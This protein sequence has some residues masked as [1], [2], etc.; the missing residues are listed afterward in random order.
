MMKLKPKLF[1][2]LLATC[3]ISLQA[4]GQNAVQKAKI[5]GKTNV[6]ELRQMQ[7]KLGKDYQ[8]NY[9]KALRI[10]KAKGWP[11]EKKLDNGKV[12]SLY[13]VDQFEKPVY[14]ISNN[15]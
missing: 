13:G 10:A 1:T 15:L 6:V 4:F 9:A 2:L 14:V 11:V 8:A 12:V 3:L 7:Q 5:A